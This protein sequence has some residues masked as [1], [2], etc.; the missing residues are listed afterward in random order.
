MTTDDENAGGSR[1]NILFLMTDQH[2]ADTPPFVRPL[3]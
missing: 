1:Q 3:G 2:R